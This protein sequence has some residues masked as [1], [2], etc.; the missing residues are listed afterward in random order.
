MKM[1][2]STPQRRR[3]QRPRVS[4]RMRKADRKRQLLAHAK[5]LFVTLGYHDTTTE[6]IAALAPMPSPSASTAAALKPGV[7]PRVRRA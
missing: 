6:K 1:P 5:Q 7:L 4:G 2:M 3:A